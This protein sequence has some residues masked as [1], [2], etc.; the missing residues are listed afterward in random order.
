MNLV[1]ISAVPSVHSTD[2]RSSERYEDETQIERSRIG[3]LSVDKYIPS[4]IESEDIHDKDNQK[5][6]HIEIEKNY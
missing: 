5:E 3:K 2:K 4:V 6:S 1:T